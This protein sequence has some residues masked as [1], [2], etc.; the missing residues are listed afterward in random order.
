M[1]I[2]IQFMNRQ[3]NPEAKATE[4]TMSRARISPATD[5]AYRR[6]SKFGEKTLCQNTY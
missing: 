4:A 1:Q 2:E 6:E 3:W 5:L